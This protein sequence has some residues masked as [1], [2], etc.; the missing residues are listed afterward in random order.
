MLS[1]ARKHMMRTRAAAETAAA[2][3]NGIRP[4][5][6]QYEL[7]L[8]QLF[9]HTQQLKNIESIKLK[10]EKKAQILPE[11]QPYI[12]GVISTDSG[13]HDDVLMTLMVWSIDA[14]DYATALTIAGYAIKHKLT[15]PDR[16]QRSTACV[17]AEEIATAALNNTLP[18]DILQRVEQLTAN[19]DM[20]DQVRAKLHKALGLDP[21][22]QTNE[23]AT[24]LN[25][26]RTALNHDERAGVKKPIEKLERQLKNM[27]AESNDSAA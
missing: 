18:L 3:A 26:L 4:D 15:M 1:P 24:A 7:M 19:Q 21:V 12:D 11:Y 25:H 8:A 20:P 5:A 23:P 14:A 2:A 13:L 17:I 27:A 10:G 22:L 9:E 6:N 16:Y